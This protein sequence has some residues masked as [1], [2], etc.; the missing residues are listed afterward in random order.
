MQNTISLGFNQIKAKKFPFDIY[1]WFLVIFS[2]KC[3]F[4]MLKNQKKPR[5]MLAT[6]YNSTAKLA[7][8]IKFYSKV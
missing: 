2:R 7:I 3:T 6:L 8:H 4:K 1:T 5:K